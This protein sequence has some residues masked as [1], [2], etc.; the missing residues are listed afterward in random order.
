MAQLYCELQPWPVRLL[1]NVMLTSESCEWHDVELCNLVLKR[2]E[3]WER[4]LNSVCLQKQLSA[5]V[6]YI[7]PTN[8]A[9]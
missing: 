8:H 6:Q 1:A 9:C 2:G 5:D 3:Y 7:I 4:C